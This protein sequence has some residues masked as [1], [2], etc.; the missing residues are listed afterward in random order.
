MFLVI[1]DD[2]HPPSWLDVD[3][4]RLRIVRLSE[5]IPAEFLP[6]YSSDT[7]EHHLWNI[8][9][10]SERFL[11]ANDD[12]M[13]YRPTLPSFFYAKD[14]YPYCRFGGE[15]REGDLGKFTV[16]RTNLL[17]SANLLVRDYGDGGDLAKACSH[18]PHHNIDAY[19][20][21]DVRACFEKY[22]SD[23]VPTF[24][25]PFRE[26]RKFQRFL[27][28]GYAIAE[29][30]AH[31]KTARAH[32]S[33]HRPWWKRLLVHGWADSLQFV[34]KN[35]LVAERELRRYRP[36][37]FCCNDTEDTKPEYFTAMKAMYERLF[38]RPSSF[39]RNAES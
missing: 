1:N 5:F 16:Y 19:L 4:P 35:W 2:N 14:G 39:E 23:L 28:S 13:F 10:L 33:A 25:F 24:D 38:P 26:L 21:S 27:Y 30:H 3:N 8:G 11:L 29:G 22:R 37:L 36:V 7:I 18:Y 15:K 12:M 9:E 34:G 17:N 31:Y 32:A 6:C 20:K